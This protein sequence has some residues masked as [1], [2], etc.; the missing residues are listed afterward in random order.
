MKK[1]PKQI[2]IEAILLKKDNVKRFLTKN[3]KAMSFCNKHGLTVFPSAQGYNALIVMLFVKKG[4]SYRKLNNIKYN[5]KEAQDVI[6][7]TAAI[8]REYERLYLKMK[9]KV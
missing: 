9:D 5:Q 3:T 7:Y 1:T 2:I 4:K 8:D 6:E